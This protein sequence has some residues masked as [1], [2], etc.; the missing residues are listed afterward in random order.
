MSNFEMLLESENFVLIAEQVFKDSCRELL[1]KLNN[2]SIDKIQEY[3]EL[4]V[5]KKTK[6]SLE[7][8]ISEALF[9]IL[10]KN[11]VLYGSFLYETQ[12]IQEDVKHEKPIL[13]TIRESSSAEYVVNSLK[14]QS[15][16]DSDKKEG[17]KG[18]KGKL[19]AGL[20]AAGLA[21]GAGYKYRN[22]IG[23]AAKVGLKKISGSMDDIKQQAGEVISG[24]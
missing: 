6:R 3:V 16:Q 4:L 15:E 14:E 1:G 5:N 7:T 17:K 8:E 10:E 23:S 12:P 19:A 20:G 9:P 24:N 11:S 22:Q 13:V 2:E 21:G 18:K